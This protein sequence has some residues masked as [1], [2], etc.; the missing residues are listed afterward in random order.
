MATN[1]NGLTYYK[2][3]SNLHGY[4][5]D[6][7]KNS[8]LR[9]EEIDGNFN[10][11]RG[12]D[13]KSVSFDDAGTLTITK[14]DGKTLTANQ[15]AEPELPDYAFS[16]D[17]EKGVFK[18]ITP[19]G[20]EIVLE[21]FN[22]ASNVHADVYHDNSL[23]GVG[24]K[25]SILQLNNICRTGRYL[26]AI[27][28]IDMTLKDEDGNQIENLPT[29]N[30]ARNDRYVTK[31][32]YTT[33]GRLYSVAGMEK[34]AKRLKEI[35]SE[36]HIPSKEEWD[37][38]LNIIDFNINNH[39]SKDN[40]V[41][42]GEFAGAV[43]KSTQYWEK[44]SNNKLLSEDTYG[45][46]ILP[47]G[48]C[49]NRG[50]NFYGSFGQSAAF[51]T[52]TL[53]DT[54]NDMY[55]K[56]FD[57]DKETV[58]QSSWGEKYYLSIRLVK[59]F[60]GT[61]FNASETIDGFVSNCVRIPNSDYIWTKENIAFSQEEYDGF[62]PEEWNDYLN[63][64][65]TNNS[66]YR[67]FVNDW[68]GTSWDKH[69]I[70]E[71]ESIVLYESENGKSRE[72][73]VVNGELIDNIGF[74][75]NE[76]NNSINNLQ[77]QITENKNI[78]DAD[79]SKINTD[80]SALNTNLRV[81]LNIETSNRA[82]E[83]EKLSTKIDKNIESLREEFNEICNTERDERIAGD[84]AITTKIDTDIIS[85]DTK[86]ANALENE[87]NERIANN[88]SLELIINKNKVTAEDSSVIVIDGT[89]DENNVTTPT[90]IKVK[91]D[92]NCEH[93][94]LDENGIY[95]DGNFGTF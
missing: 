76:T 31:E 60:T 29:E 93:I 67:Y 17:S 21:G 27:K 23:V 62:I 66:N 45:F 55:V 50:K 32:S 2:L 78:H 57:Y 92:S 95:F 63:E 65:Y 9:G 52:T 80:I 14:Y 42:L 84:N 1:I 89:I 68:N 72:W 35:N 41:D 71:G 15:I 20:E 61:N 43:L 83:D 4:P 58:G 73:I 77:S 44:T 87:K 8:G 12:N 75:S 36:W 26:P 13:I 25:K 86:F 5:G 3:D 54:Y 74:L 30:I 19:K 6:I 56:I 79:F 64:S 34:I 28:L 46:S 82:E 59:K 88:N 37:E 51:W 85:L 16:Y 22:I 94:K 40:N 18:I 49:G 81:E 91:I 69:E 48:Y 38:L 7:T 39:D 53:E 11:L 24:S 10:F 47:V 33:F 70:K 90:T